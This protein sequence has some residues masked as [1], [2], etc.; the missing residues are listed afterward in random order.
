MFRF[1][2]NLFSI[3]RGVF[4]KRRR[5]VKYLGI[6]LHLADERV[7]IKYLRRETMYLYSFPDQDDSSWEP[8]SNVT[9]LSYQPSVDH[10]GR[11]AFVDPPLP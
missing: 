3:K 11:Y 7:H 6:V 5:I 1:G 8:L 10:R 2:S 4:R 9:V